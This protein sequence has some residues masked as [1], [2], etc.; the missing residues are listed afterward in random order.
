MESLISQLSDDKYQFQKIDPY[1]W[2]CGPWSQMTKIFIK[3]LIS[4]LVYI[5]FLSKI[6][7]QKLVFSF[8]IFLFLLVLKMFTALFI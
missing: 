6:I 2:F 8:F 4:C 5:I 7:S 1:V 3:V